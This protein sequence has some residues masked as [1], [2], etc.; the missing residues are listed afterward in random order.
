[1][2]VAEV[3]GEDT[4][5]PPRKH[6]SAG[7]ITSDLLESLNRT[8]RA[9]HLELWQQNVDAIFNNNN[10]QKLKAAYG[11]G[12]YNSM[13]NM[14][15]RMKT[16]RNRPG[17]RSS[18]EDK[19][20]KQFEDWLTG[21]I[22]VT[23]F[24]NTRSAALQMISTFNF[25]DFKDNNILA[26]SKAFANQKQFWSDFKMLYNSDFLTDRRDGLRLDV[27][28]AD[29]SDLARDGG[30]KGVIASLLK[31]GFTPTQVADSF[32]ISLGGAAW[33]RNRFNALVKDEMHPEAAAKLA[34]REFREV[35]ETSQ[36]SSRADKISSEQAGSAG[37]MIMAFANTPSQ[38]TRIIKKAALDL[39][40]GRGDAKTHVSKIL[41]YGFMQNAIFTVLQNALV[42]TLFEEDEDPLI[43][44]K[45]LDTANSM[46]DSFI[47]GAGIRGAVIVVLK[48]MVIRFFKEEKKQNPKEF[49]LVLEALKI[50]P[51]IHSKANKLYKSYASYSWGKE[52]M[53]AK[54]AGLTSPA[55]TIGTNL[56]AGASNVP[57]DRIL[58]K[59]R[60]IKRSTEEDLAFYQRV[61]LMM[62]WPDWQVGADQPFKKKK[63]KKAKVK[64]S[65][66]SFKRRSTRQRTYQRR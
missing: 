59:V 2:L 8:N 38:Y 48:N 51:P 55:W 17:V 43:Q 61:T 29:L 54:G 9:T 28:E 25:I 34:M 31:F 6:W 56:V 21:S 58:K 52:E 18:T 7:S 50:S 14:L 13:K 39:K 3:N 4:Y 33:Y 41:Y 32:A 26:A 16:G 19:T 60:N 20:G 23:M 5:E 22:G 64:P 12:Y 47:R 66:S 65:R 1:M 11:L 57:V 49:A 44:S 45:I 10:M 15:E 37:R 24:L 30:Y 27:N 36:Q 46:T 63:K 53:K 42:F 40:N 35:A 62:G